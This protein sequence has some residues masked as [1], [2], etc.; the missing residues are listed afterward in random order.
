MMEVILTVANNNANVPE[1]RGKFQVSVDL[2]IIRVVAAMSACVA[3]YETVRRTFENVALCVNK[4]LYMTHTLTWNSVQDCYKR[5]QEGF[6]KDYL[7]YSGLSGVAGGTM[8]ELQQ[9]LSQMRE[10]GDSFLNQ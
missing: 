7:R 10:K 8:R 3:V 5:L 9:A 4:I 6:D 2:I 1:K